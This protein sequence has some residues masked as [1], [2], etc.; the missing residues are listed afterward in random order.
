MDIYERAC[1]KVP[2]DEKLELYELYASRAM[3]SFGVGKVRNIYEAAIGQNLPDGVTKVLCTRYARLERK[4]GEVDRARGLYI[5]ASQFANPQQESGF[6]EEWNQFEIRHGNEDTF[7]EMLRIKRS[8]SAS[9]SQTHFNMATVELVSHAGNSESG[10][11]HPPMTSRPQE[12]EALEESVA[13]LERG[14]LSDTIEG[15]VKAHTEGGGGV[16]VGVVSSID[17]PDE[18]DIG[19]E[20]VEEDGTV[21]EGIDVEQ[22]LLPESLFSRNVEVGARDQSAGALDRFKRQKV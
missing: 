5:H 11:L 8:V 10:H 19:D 3:D 6:W 9:F 2:N 20:E 15:F 18:I 13:E 4:L 14:G 22:T 17:N 1:K 7:R 21:G 16:A 12:S